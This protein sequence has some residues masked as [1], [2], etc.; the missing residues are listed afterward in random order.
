MGKDKS[1]NKSNPKFWKDIRPI[2]INPIK[3]IKM[4][5][6]RL[7]EKLGKFNSISPFPVR[8]LL[9]RLLTLGYLVLQS[10]LF[11]KVPLISPPVHPE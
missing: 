3:S 6:G 2:R 10:L 4:V 5:I 11:L 8:L 9:L 7:T 1:G